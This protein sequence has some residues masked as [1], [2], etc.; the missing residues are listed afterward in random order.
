MASSSDFSSTFNNLASSQSR[1]E[2]PLLVNL[3]VRNMTVRKS[4]VEA[5]EL[6]NAVCNDVRR[7]L[8]QLQ[9]VLMATSM[10]HTGKTE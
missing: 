8:D 2:K 4:P 7:Y 1:F 6:V 10:G 5:K 3:Q 9:L